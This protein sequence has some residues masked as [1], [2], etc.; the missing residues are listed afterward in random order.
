[1]AVEILKKK[2]QKERLGKTFSKIENFSVTLAHLSNDIS[3]ITNHVNKGKGAAGAILMDEKFEKDLV[4]TL[5]SIKRAS[6]GLEE[7]MEALKHNFLFR[8]YYK[9]LTKTQ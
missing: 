1:M 5:E 2:K 8:R 3:S 6:K 4:E 9:K 7:N